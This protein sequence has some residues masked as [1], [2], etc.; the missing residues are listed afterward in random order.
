MALAASGISPDLSELVTW[1]K[2][3]QATDE[4]YMIDALIRIHM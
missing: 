3:H 2:S 4:K 1:S